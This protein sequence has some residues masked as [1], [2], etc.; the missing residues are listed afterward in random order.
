ME[1]NKNYNDNGEFFTRFTN[2]KATLKRIQEWSLKT[3]TQKFGLNQFS[4][5]SH[6]EVSKFNSLKI[7][8]T[9]E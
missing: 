4:D 9:E 7:D 5:W 2:F 8:E 3:S 1:Y 6:E